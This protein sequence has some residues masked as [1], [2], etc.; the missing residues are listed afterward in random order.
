MPSHKS[1]LAMAA[2]AAVAQAATLNDICTTSYTTAALPTLPGL[3]IDSTS[4][5]AAITSNS[6]VSSEWYPSAVIECKRASFTIPQSTRV[7][8]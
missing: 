6:S 4:L 8:L 7:K 5:T 1:A 2:S 3:T